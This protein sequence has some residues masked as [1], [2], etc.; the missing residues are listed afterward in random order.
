MKTAKWALAN[1]TEEAKLSSP[2]GNLTEKYKQKYKVLWLSFSDVDVDYVNFTA[3]DL[4][5]DAYDW[6]RT[7]VKEAVINYPWHNVN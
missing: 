2:G 4:C 5:S 1:I 7:F 3:S 6:Y